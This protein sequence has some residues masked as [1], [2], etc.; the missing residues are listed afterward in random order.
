MTEL[1]DD[2]LDYLRHNQGR[3]PATAIKYGGYLRRLAGWIQEAGGHLLTLSSDD[4]E[5]F[6]GLV[7]HKEGLS[8]RSRRALVAAVR[9][10][11]SWARSRGHIRQD[12]AAGLPYPR[13]G[14][15]LPT[16]MQLRHAEKLL[17]QPDI[18]TFTG[19]R[20]AAILSVLIGCGLRI[21]GL[22]ALNEGDLI[23]TDVDGVEWM[24]I[25]TR[26]KG[27][28]ERL[29]PAPHETRLLVRA[30]LGHQELE[31][32]DRHLENGDQ[33]LFV[34][35]RNRTVPEH[36]FRGEE[37]RLAQRTIRDMIVRYGE[38]AGIPRKELH[39][40]A[41]RHLY[42]TELAEDDVDLLVRQTLMGHV[43]SNS[44]KIYTHLAMRKLT[45]HMGKANPL[46][47]VKTPVT[48]LLRHLQRD[49]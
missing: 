10:F 21:G 28:R 42:G 5:Q 11:Y 35:T 12:P 49:P 6:T 26:E 38:A 44:T 13:A 24:I 20:D 40:H 48:D 33:V 14:L 41:M 31:H 9:G 7:M 34:S 36:Q 39:P 27:D 32:I 15:K 22:C 3:S 30:Y 4:L 17:M 16:P 2:Y 47:K 43:D 37:R 25:R 1:I 23:F 19:V 45:Q 46:S 29:L 8:P 18:S